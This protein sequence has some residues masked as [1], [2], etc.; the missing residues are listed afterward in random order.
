[1]SGKKTLL[2]KSAY[3]AGLVRDRLVR[4]EL[5][6]LEAWLLSSCP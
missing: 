3:L 6:D 1:M 4:I 2:T 5:L